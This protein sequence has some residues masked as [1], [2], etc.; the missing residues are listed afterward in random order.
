MEEDT[1]NEIVEPAYGSE[2]LSE[3][4]PV[5]KKAKKKA[6]KKAIV[7][8]VANSTSAPQGASF[9]NIHGERVGVLCLK[10]GEVATFDNLQTA[11]ATKHRYGGR[12][13]NSDGLIR[14][15]RR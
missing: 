12:L 1:L 15:K 5:K 6:A 8:K 3:K 14:L 7:K 10:N 11:V 2:L 13:S 9:K 4:V